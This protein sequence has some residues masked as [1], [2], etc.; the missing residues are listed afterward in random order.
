M[1]MTEDLAMLSACY[2]EGVPDG[3][4]L[5]LIAQAIHGGDMVETDADTRGKIELVQGELLELPQVD[6]PL[7]HFFTP[8]GVYARQI[9]MPRGAL[10]MGRIHLTGHLNIILQGDCTLFTKDGPKRIRAPFVFES[11]PGTKKLLYINE[12]TLWLT[13]HVMPKMDIAVIENTLTVDSFAEYDALMLERQR[14]LT[15]QGDEQ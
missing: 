15:A 9:F 13:T 12:D 4:P 8:D 7:T 6:C 5:A 11:S 2:P 3:F 14:A 1:E 10:V